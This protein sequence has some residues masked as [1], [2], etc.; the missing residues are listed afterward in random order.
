MNNLANTQNA[1][2]GQREID[3]HEVCV[4]VSQT[5]YYEIPS[6]EQIT[7]KNKTQHAETHTNKPAANE[8]LFSVVNGDLDDIE[9]TSWLIDDWIP[10]ESLVCTYA[11][12]ASLKSFLV[13]DLALHICT[14]KAWN[15]HNV[16]Q[17]TV[18][19]IAGEGRKGILKRAAA[20]RKHH[21]AEAI[22]NFYVSN[23]AIE[24]LDKTG[25]EL[26]ITEAKEVIEKHGGINM[27]V[28]DT[29][30]RNFGAGDENKTKDMTSF[31]GSVSRLLSQTKA[32]V[33]IVHHTSKA[34]ASLARGSGALRAALDCE[35]MIDAERDSEDKVKKMTLSCKKMKDDDLPA[36]LKFKPL[37]VKIDKL[38]SKGKQITSLVLNAEDGLF[39]SAQKELLKHIKQLV[40]EDG[41]N[42]TEKKVN[43]IVY[44]YHEILKRIL[45]SDLK[46]DIVF[47]YSELAEAY[48]GKSDNSDV[49]PNEKSRFMKYISEI[50]LVNKATVS[51]EVRYIFSI[52]AS[53]GMSNKQFISIREKSFSQ[54]AHLDNIV[55]SSFLD[56]LTLDNIRNA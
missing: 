30:N 29:L 39:E 27:I 16:E 33:H 46:T 55:K 32:S 41:G 52:N 6:Q 17:G 44:I 38:D 5:T 8:P 28:I 12:S 50:S 15:G 45:S 35:Y 51:G 7:S 4:T 19:Y 56:S 18:L 3:N 24:F 2:E 10:K 53:N 37:V 1:L 22:N 31:I 13:I 23:T 36:A 11:P 54:H 40:K 20:W 26:L 42:V 9:T 47:T 14:G 25:V 49:S 21:G 34:D 43:V 48:F